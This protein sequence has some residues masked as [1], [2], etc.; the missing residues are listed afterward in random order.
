MVL[1]RDEDDIYVPEELKEC[2]EL[3]PSAKSS[4]EKLETSR[5]KEL[6]SYIYGLKDETNRAERIALLMKNNWAMGK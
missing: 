1:Y 5:K 6:I 3:D 2:L 4:F